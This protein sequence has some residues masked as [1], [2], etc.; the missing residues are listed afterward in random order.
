MGRPLDIPAVHATVYGD[1][2]DALEITPL[3]GVVV[4]PFDGSLPK[5]V[6]RGIVE[7]WNSG[8]TVA[9][10]KSCSHFRMIQHGEW[11]IFVRVE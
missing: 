8:L 2:I 5:R 1:I 11:V 3:H 7:R 10:R 6:F 9:S 4:V